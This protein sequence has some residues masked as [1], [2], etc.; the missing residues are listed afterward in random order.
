MD[1]DVVGTPAAE[2][3]LIRLLT[4]SDVAHRWGTS[5][6]SAREI[7]GVFMLRIFQTKKDGIL[8]SEREVQEL[9]E[10][11]CSRGV[12]QRVG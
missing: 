8:F 3:V 11:R 2:A 5:K 4:L 1:I 6:K 7:L 10:E 9:E 12:W